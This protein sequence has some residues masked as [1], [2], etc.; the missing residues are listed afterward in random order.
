LNLIT[1]PYQSY[2]TAAQF[3]G[4]YPSDVEF[5]AMPKSKLTSQTPR[6][7]KLKPKKLQI[8]SDMD[9]RFI[10]A[11]QQ[12]NYKFNIQE[13]SNN[14]SRPVQPG[15]VMPLAK[16][17]RPSTSKVNNLIKSQK[18]ELQRQVVEEEDDN[19]ERVKVESVG[20]SSADQPIPDYSAYFPRSIFR[21]AGE[22]DEAT[23]ILEPNSMAVSGNDG[24]SISTPLSRAL[25]RKGTAVRVLFRPQSVAISG[26][27]G[28]SHAQADLILDFIDE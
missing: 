27:G 26:A 23:L 18:L 3:Y 14:P 11:V 22:G 16:F 19:E 9:V 28:T 12:P 2:Q 5:V 21:Q 4:K 7:S 10:Q 13:F 24:T 20:M 6:K 25:L 8:L 15:I 1:P 17:I